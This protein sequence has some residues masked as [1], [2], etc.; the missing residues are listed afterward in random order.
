MTRQGHHGCDRH[1][2]DP[3]HRCDFGYTAFGA[4]PN[5]GLIGD[6]IFLDRNNSG[7]P[8]A[9]EAVE[10][11]VVE[12][13]DA[14]NNL[15]ATTVTDENGNYYFADLPVTGP[16]VT[17]NVVVAA[18]NFAAGGPLQGTT[19]SVDPDGGNNSTSQVVLTTGSPIN[20]AQD[21][22][23]VASAPGSIGNLVWN[24]LNANGVVDA[25][26]NGIP[27]VTV[28]LYRDLERQRPD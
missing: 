4:K 5:R 13:R 14:S 25:G 11:V 20:L 26:E 18:S 22:G 21:F 24:D 9:G 7:A 2:A 8:D 23:Y 1:H 27:G 3:D 12:L 10:G 19:N 6:T 28:D 16:G 17:Y 15:I